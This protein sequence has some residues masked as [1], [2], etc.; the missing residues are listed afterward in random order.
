MTVIIPSDQEGLVKRHQEELAELVEA[1][2]AAS[3]DK[4]V[5][6]GRMLGGFFGSFVWGIANGHGECSNCGFPYA[7]YHWQELDRYPGRTKLGFPFEPETLL[8]MAFVP[9][10]EMP[11][12]QPGISPEERAEEAEK[13]RTS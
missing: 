8:L 7:Y 2:D 12:A 9:N 3:V 13:G 10:A 5:N 1:L 6:C 11:L 4:C